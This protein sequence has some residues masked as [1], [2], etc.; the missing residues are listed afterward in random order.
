M[1]KICPD[2]LTVFTG[3]SDVEICPVEHC[4]RWRL[5]PVDD[6]FVDVVWKFMRMLIGFN[7]VEGGTLEEHCH[8]LV[9]FNDTWLE[10]SE[11]TFEMFRELALKVNDGGGSVGES[12]QMNG[13]RVMLVE[14]VSDSEDGCPI[15]RLDDQVTFVK[16][17]Y[18]LLYE[19]VE[20]REAIFK[21]AV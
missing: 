10:G 11:F 8:A 19:V 3:Y 7:R 12:D 21:L 1:K 2:C 16:Y 5:L 13:Y 17:L 9:C 15:C 6:I 18:R 4:E 14:S 20:E